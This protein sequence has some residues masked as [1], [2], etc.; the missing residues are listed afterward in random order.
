MSV[1][2]TKAMVLA[3]GLGVRMRPLTDRL[4]K[5]LVKVGGKALIDHVLDRLANAGVER[6][7]VNVHHFAD[8]LEGH[9]ARRRRPHIAIA[10]ERAKLLGTGARVRRAATQ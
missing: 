2:P 4:P 1:H 6:A 7:V 8:Q 5:P 10:A 3:A 9:L